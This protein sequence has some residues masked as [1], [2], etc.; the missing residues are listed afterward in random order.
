MLSYLKPYNPVHPNTISRWIKLVLER[1][2]I[3]TD[4]FKAHS[5]RAA[6][7]SAASMKEVNV[8]TIIKTAG[9]SN[10]KTF[11]KFYNKP[12][13]DNDFA[14]AILASSSSCVLAEL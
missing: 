9:W 4:I 2:G 14:E 10:A 6:S 5:T 1:A 3:S 8:E 7:T 11:A 13:A 12:I